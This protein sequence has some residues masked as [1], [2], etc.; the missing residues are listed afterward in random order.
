MAFELTL[1][2]IIILIILALISLFFGIKILI[3]YKL[4]HK[5]THLIWGIILTFV[6]P[7]LIIYVLLGSYRMNTMIDYGPGPV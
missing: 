2:G 6:I 4:T 3:K 7:G 1:A 5:R